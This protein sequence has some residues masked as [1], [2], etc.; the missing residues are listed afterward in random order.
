MLASI[1]SDNAVVENGSRTQA[2][3]AILLLEGPT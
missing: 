2:D 1:M 3:L